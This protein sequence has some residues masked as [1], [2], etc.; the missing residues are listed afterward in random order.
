MQQKRIN[1]GNDLY[2]TLN[3]YGKIELRLNSLLEEKGISKTMLAKQTKLKYDVVKRY[4]DDA[5]SRFDREV[6]VKICYCLECEISDLL[7]YKKS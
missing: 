6:L 5:P 3:S 2:E 4:C 1:K 7:V